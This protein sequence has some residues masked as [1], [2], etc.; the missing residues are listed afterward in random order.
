MF[1][2]SAPAPTSPVGGKTS[3]AGCEYDTFA[4]S[5]YL[6]AFVD[7]NFGSWLRSFYCTLDGFESGPDSAWVLYFMEGY[8]ITIE[9]LQDTFFNFIVQYGFNIRKE[10]WR[11]SNL[12]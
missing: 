7:A 9:E 6:R 3:G 2:A 12:P 8:G 11:I 1:A 10:D 4:V 5:T